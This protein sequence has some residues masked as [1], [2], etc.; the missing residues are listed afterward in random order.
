MKKNLLGKI[1]ILKKIHPYPGNSGKHLECIG[2]RRT[3]GPVPGDL[4]NLSKGRNINATSP[5]LRW[6]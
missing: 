2:S 5:V 4:A 6:L 1:V 3:E